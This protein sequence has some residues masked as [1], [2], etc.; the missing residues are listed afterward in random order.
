M[1]SGAVQ[2]STAKTCGHW[3]SVLC[4]H[5]ELAE[6]PPIRRAH[7]RDY[8]RYD[9]PV[10]A[11]RVEY[12]SAAAGNKLTQVWGALLDLSPRGVMIRS[13][14]A[15]RESTVCRME[16]ALEDEIIDVQGIVRHCTETVGG[17]KIGIELCFEAAEP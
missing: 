1:G 17:Y 10:G 13:H 15:I 7:R 6:E 4:R 14:L 2:R 12:L 8:F 5:F 11:A 3:L 16:V 9:T